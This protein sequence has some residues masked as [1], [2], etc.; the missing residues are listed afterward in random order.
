MKN[1]NTSASRELT[2]IAYAVAVFVI[3][4]FF[5]TSY[6]FA[7]MYGRSG[8][9]FGNQ[10]TLTLSNVLNILRDN[11]PE[12]SQSEQAVSNAAN[13][14]GNASESNPAPQN[15]QNGPDVHA[16][17]CVQTLSVTTPPECGN[18]NGGATAG[19]G[20]D[21]GSGG[22]SGL[23]RAGDTVSNSTAVNAI[24]TNIIRFSLR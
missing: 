14:G 23:V 1:I 3:A 21:G 16:S 5:C 24:N 20:G 8:I 9:S 19:N 4:L 15:A 7:D 13:N 2:R 17:E 12:E 18:N 6:A 10:R 22:P 11:T